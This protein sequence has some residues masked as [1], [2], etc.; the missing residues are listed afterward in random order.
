[1]RLTRLDAAVRMRHTSSGG[2]PARV[3]NGALRGGFAATCMVLLLSR[4]PATK[5][6]AP[7]R[8]GNQALK[9]EIL[10]I[11]R[12]R[13]DYLRSGAFAWTEAVTIPKGGYSDTLREMNGPKWGEQMGAAVDAVIPP[14]DTTY[15]VKSALWWDVGGKMRYTYDNQT[16][17]VKDGRYVA[18]RYISTFDGSQ[19]KILRPDGSPYA[20]HSQGSIRLEKRHEDGRV[21]SHLPF[22]LLFRALDHD[23]GPFET[24]SMTVAGQ[25]AFVNGVSCVE[26]QQHQGRSLLR[27][28]ADPARG[29][30]VVRMLE[31]NNGRPQCQQDISYRPDPEAG[32]APENW[33]SV[34]FKSDGRLDRSV[35]ATL[36]EFRVNPSLPAEEFD[37]EFPPGTSVWDLKQ[38]TRYIAKAGGRKRPVPQHEMGFSH[39]QLLNTEPTALDGGRGVSWTAI[40]AVGVFFISAGLL[41]WRRGWHWR[42]RE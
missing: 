21:I 5:A 38:K 33:T 11:W 41:A 13:Q 28:W 18:S 15:E 14:E 20:R 42:T 35:R 34:F 31:T 3:V 8:G 27:H 1:M 4:P 24:E 7:E 30:V 10:K 22:R 17:S 9:Q 36:T 26:L 12:E 23:L 29:Y 16:W 19:A 37:I 2:V 6:R 25:R 40:A 39:E 32:W